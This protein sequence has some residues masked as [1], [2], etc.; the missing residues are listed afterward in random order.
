MSLTAAV[1]NEDLRSFYL[2]SPAGAGQDEMPG[3]LDRLL[4]SD[5]AR[6]DWRDRVA[7]VLEGLDGEQ[8]EF[9]K[10]GLAYHISRK[11]NS[12]RLSTKAHVRVTV[13]KPGDGE[14]S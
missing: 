2:G 6:D 4:D 12:L 13:P 1:Q 14:D 9:L 8:V 7:E 10:F 11:A 5:C 3:R